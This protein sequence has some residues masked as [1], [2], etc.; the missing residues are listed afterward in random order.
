MFKL[1]SKVREILN[2]PDQVIPYL[3]QQARTSVYLI[4]SHQYKKTVYTLLNELTSV[5]NFTHS[6]W[7]SIIKEVNGTKM[8]LDLRDRGINRDLLLDGIREEEE[9]REFENQLEQLKTEYDKVQVF[10]IGANIGYYVLLEASVLGNE[11]RIYAFEPHPTNVAQLRKSIKL[12]SFD[13]FVQVEQ[14]AIGA[15]TGTVDLAI[16]PYS[17][18]HR[19]NGIK[20]GSSTTIEVPIKPIDHVLSEKGIPKADCLLFR[21]DVEGFEHRVFAG[22]DKVLSSNQDIFIFVEVHSSVPQDEI[23]KMMNVLL[24]CGFELVYTGERTIDSL[25]DLVTS[26]S[27]HVM[28][29]RTSQMNV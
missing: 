11:H 27:F 25:G 7:H 17:N 19:I 4:E 26:S 28:A 3:R 16:S 6:D 22:M 21:I 2:Q 12:N 10:D 8:V 15:E 18:T 23:S 13:D 1:T 29:K 9:T 20:E 5:D 14:C 24:D